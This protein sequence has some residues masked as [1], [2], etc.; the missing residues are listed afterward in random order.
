V[1]YDPSS[2]ILFVKEDGCRVTDIKGKTYLDAFAGLMYK[3]VG[4]GRTEIADVIHEQ[5]LQLSSCVGSYPNIPQIELAKKLADITPGDLLVSFMGCNGSDA[6]ETGVKMARHYQKI[7]GYHNRYKIICRRREYHGMNFGSMS[8]GHPIRANNPLLVEDYGLY[9]PLMPGVIHIPNCYCYRCEFDLTYPNC[10]LQC[11]RYLETVI[12]REKPESIAVVLGTPVS[13]HTLGTVP[14]PEYWPKI[15]SI[16]DKYGIL[17]M[18][19]CVVTG[20]GRTGKMFAIEHWNVV[21]DIMGIA[22][23]VVSGYLPLA[24]TITNEKVAAKLDQEAFAHHYTFGWHPAACAAALKN[25]EIIQSERLVENSRTVG[26]YLLD[27]LQTM[28]K[29]PTV[30]DVRGIG[31]F[32]VVEF[33]RDKKTKEPF[34]TPTTAKLGRKLVQARLL[35]RTRDSSTSIL[36]PLIF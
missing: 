20:F 29:H 31:L 22:K 2:F 21:P 9:G 24:A 33:V 19:D 16:C 32:C 36:P 28:R 4:Y 11:A 8:L 7:S 15:R 26:E 1:S 13:C 12:I 30:G 14:P 23:G 3:N 18:V 27:Q 6:N 34:D 35:T 5:L 10:E 17:L 25:I